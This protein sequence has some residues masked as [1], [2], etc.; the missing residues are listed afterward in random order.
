MSAA[1]STLLNVL[2]YVEQHEP[3]PITIFDNPVAALMEMQHMADETA[4]MLGVAPIV[5]NLPGLTI[6]DGSGICQLASYPDY[7]WFLTDFL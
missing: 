7:V 2:E 6:F 1:A 5:S 4:R 3:Y